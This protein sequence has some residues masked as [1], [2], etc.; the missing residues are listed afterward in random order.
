MNNVEFHNLYCFQGVGY[1]RTGAKWV[2][3]VACMR[4]KIILNRFLIGK[5]EGESPFRR[6][7]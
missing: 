6:P 1:Q 2:R 7:V 4:Q 3:N 5:W